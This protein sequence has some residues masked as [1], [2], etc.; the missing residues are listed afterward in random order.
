MDEL[1]QR[2]DGAVV[3]CLVFKKPIRECCDVFLQGVVPQEGVVNP[4]SMT[5]KA[6]LEGPRHKEW[7][8][9]ISL[10]FSPSMFDKR[11]P[12]LPTEPLTT[13]NKDFW[14]LLNPQKLGEEQTKVPKC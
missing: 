13:F 10:G 3:T 1:S 5:G 6:I 14:T 4:E 8:S 12:S 7:L 11:Y 2:I 9:A